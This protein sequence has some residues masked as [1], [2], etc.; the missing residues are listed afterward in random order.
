MNN[1]FSEEDAEINIQK[2]PK[3]LKGSIRGKYNRRVKNLAYTLKDFIDHTENRLNPNI[4]N[5]INNKKEI[6]QFL[7]KA[8]EFL[9]LIP[10]KY[11]LELKSTK[12]IDTKNL[13][14]IFGIE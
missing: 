3:D 8:K 9:N 6:E 5:K 10:E 2:D 7:E 4:F 13:N 14:K 12:Q 11:Y 1:F